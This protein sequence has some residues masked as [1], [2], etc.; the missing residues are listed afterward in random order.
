MSVETPTIVNDV[1][2]GFPQSLHVHEGMVHQI[3]TR[4]IP[5]T[6]FPIQCYIARTIDSIIK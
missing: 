5:F 3:G 4:L 1:L 2:R 6:L